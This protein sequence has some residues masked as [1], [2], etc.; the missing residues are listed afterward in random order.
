[1]TNTIYFWGCQ[2]PARFPFIERATRLVLERLKVQARDIDGFTCCPEKSL[3]TNMDEYTW[4]LTAARNLALA[5]SQ[6]GKT[7]LTPCNGCYSTFKTVMGKL[8]SDPILS[9]RINQDLA[10]VNLT[11]HGRIKIQHIVE[12][13]SEEIGADRLQANMQSPLW[14]MKIATH[15]GCHLLRPGHATSF[16]NPLRPTKF[17]A[18]VEALGATSPDFN[19]KFLCCGEALGRSGEVE[20]GVVLARQ[21][22]L[23][24]DFLAFDAI[25]VSCPA[26]YL[27]FDTQQALLRR[28]G[29]SF[30][31][32]VFHI[33]ELVGL[34]L[35]ISPEELGLNLHRIKFDRFLHNWEHKSRTLN[36]IEEFFP[37]ANLQ[38]CSQC[39]A[40]EHDCPSALN[41]PNFSPQAIIADI[42]AGKID[43]YLGTKD[44]WNCL[45]CHT[46]TELCPSHFGMEKVFKALKHMAITQQLVPDGISNMMETF[47]KTGRL[48]EPQKSMRRKL[49]LPQPGASGAADWK[50]LM[51]ECNRE[52]E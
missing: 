21:K 2:V 44:I 9:R 19:S 18:L 17:D 10:A 7:L 1:M 32:P 14:G 34:A 33:S 11:Y 26:C 50:K 46:C 40:C 42:L 5:E 3:V 28:K 15:Y 36:M 38:R 29:D 24:M 8:K 47:R 39:G 49:N 41:V 23:E 13:F 48:G 37:L 12:F 45:E 35:G 22:L 4:Y 20:Q 25:V 30:N 27:Q 16:D 6:G 51:H 52:T 31:L 43:H